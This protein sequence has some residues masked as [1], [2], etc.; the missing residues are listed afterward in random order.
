MD[1]PPAIPYM[2]PILEDLEFIEKSRHP[3]EYLKITNW[4]I[5]VQNYPIRRVH[6]DWYSHEFR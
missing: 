4:T 2:R 6:I 1:K 3:E 5:K